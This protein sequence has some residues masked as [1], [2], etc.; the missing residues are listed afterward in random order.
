M[1][2]LGNTLSGGIVPAA[3]ASGYSASF[4]G[5]DEYIDLGNNSALRP[6]LGSGNSI[7]MSLWAKWTNV[8]S[9]TGQLFAIG[10]SSSNYTG[11][12]TNIN[13]SG[14]ISV[15]TGDGSGQGSTDRR[16]LKTDSNHLTND[17][18]HHIAFVLP[19]AVSSNFAIWIDGV[20]VAAT[21]SGNGGAMTYDGTNSA[22]IGKRESP[23][24]AVY[25]SAGLIDEVGLFNAE[26][27]SSDI[28][29]IYNSG[30]TPGS[31][32][33]ISGLIGY[34]KMEEGTG[35]EVTDSS[36]NSNTGTL[37]NGTTWD[38]DTP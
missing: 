25:A 20:D 10:T 12:W 29:S 23:Y 9:G 32:S 19:D 35:S 4:G 8:T 37:T 15:H 31:L 24:G 38:S 33:G 27:G 26:L 14:L 11:V 17:T 3:A 16:S 6:S 30:G 28:A 18:W 36:T 1:L 22:F 2:G 34:W 21:T 5:D 7:S 13:S